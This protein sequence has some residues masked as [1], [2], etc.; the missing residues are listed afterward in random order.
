M[1]VLAGFIRLSDLM[2]CIL[3]KTKKNPSPVCERKRT[4]IT[5][6]MIAQAII[7]VKAKGAEVSAQ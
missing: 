5:I 2:Y 1:L 6:T 7:K 3:S 4:P